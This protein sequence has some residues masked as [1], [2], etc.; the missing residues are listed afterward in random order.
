MIGNDDNSRHNDYDHQHQKS[1]KSEP[2]EKVTISRIDT[3][4]NTN[5]T[6]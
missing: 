2:K 6:K 3:N 5:E 1:E 4:H